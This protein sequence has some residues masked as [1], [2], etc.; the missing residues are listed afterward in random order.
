MW[1]SASSSSPWSCFSP[2]SPLAWAP[3]PA[4]MDTFLSK[5][6]AKTWDVRLAKI[7]K[8]VAVAFMALTLV[9][10]LFL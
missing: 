2:A 9:L 6:K 8:W 10:V 1:F 3:S 4:G 5:N 7:T